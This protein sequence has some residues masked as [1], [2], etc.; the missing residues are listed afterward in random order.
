MENSGG[1][2]NGNP[3]DLGLSKA[4]LRAVAKRPVGGSLKNFLRDLL[5]LCSFAALKRAVA[6]F[7]RD[8]APGLAAQLAYYLIL[9]LF[10]FLLV[11]VSLMGTFSSPELAN[12]VLEHFQQ[13][14]PQ[15]VYGLIDSYLGDI[16]SG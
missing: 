7:Q 10:P 6:E 8:D 11:L 4:Q 12:S 1:K 13:V 3:E 15:E 9:A 14:T 2:K 16:L 5:T